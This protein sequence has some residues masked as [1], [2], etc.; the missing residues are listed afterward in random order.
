[1]VRFHTLDAMRGTA[2]LSVAFFHVDR[3]N[4]CGYLAVDLFFMLSGFV[5]VHAYGREGL[6]VGSFMLTRAIRLYPL[7][8][9]G[10]LVGLAR[11]GGNPF[12]LLMVPDWTSSRL[13][14][15]NVALWSVFYEMIASFAFA[16]LYRF[17]WKAWAI[18]FAISAAVWLSFLAT[19]SHGG[20][21]W[22][23]AEVPHGL[24]RMT[25][26]FTSGI[27]LYW[28]YRQISWRANTNWAW[29]LCIAP[30]ALSFAPEGPLVLPVLVGFAFPALILSGALIEPSHWGLAKFSGDISYPLYAIHQPIVLA[31]GWISIPGII[32]LAYVLDRYYDRPVRRWL[33]DRRAHRPK[34]TTLPP[35]IFPPA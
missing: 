23:W 8:A 7:F 26:A 2:A 28:I 22:T 16:L 25:F 17:G 32:A 34:T 14:P 15:S 13:F 20:Q 4:P 30:A 6:N 19:H 29:L 5:L 3:L 35:V 9:V 33:S 21:G 31:F 11:M 24:V 18:P 12:T 1:M 10:V 27:A